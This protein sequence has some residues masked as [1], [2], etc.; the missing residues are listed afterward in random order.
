MTSHSQ[1]AVTVFFEQVG[2]DVVATW[3]GSIDLG[4]W[5]R[6]QLGFNSGAGPTL[7]YD[8]QSSVEVYNNGLASNVSGFG[9]IVDSS[10][11]GSIGIVNNEFA[12]T[13]DGIVGAPASSIYN[14]DLNPFVM[15][16]ETDLLSS[17]GA[18][19]FNNTLAWTSSAGGDNTVSYTTV[20]EP[21]STALIGF[22][23]LGLI[24]RRRR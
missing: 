13:S 7:L 23:A 24:I 5:D 2:D 22:G 17:I 21:S 8:F 16:F 6:N 18:S 3:T 20:P 15:T 19:S 9:G 12:V 10:E 11:G 1:A 14:F 4:D